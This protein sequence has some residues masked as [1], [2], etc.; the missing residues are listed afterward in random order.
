MSGLGDG[1]PRVR[2]VGGRGEVR[3]GQL[4]PRREE[5]Q[6]REGGDQRGLQ[7]RAVQR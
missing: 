3:D 7:V 5:H 4:Q 6:A 2:E 1:L